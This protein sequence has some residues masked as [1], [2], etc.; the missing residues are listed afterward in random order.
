MDKT[1]RLWHISRSECLCCFKHSDFVTSIQFHPRD[2]RFFLAGSLDSKLRLWSIPDKSVAYWTHVA[3]MVTAVAFS[4]DGKTAI[5]GCLNGLCLFYDTEGLKIQSQLHV[6][7]SKG[8]KKGSKITGIK[9]MTNAPIDPNGEVKLLITSNDSRVRLYNLKDRNME[10]KFRGNENT[11]SQIH[12]TFSD[13]G[14][15]VICGSEDRKAYIWPTG[16]LENNQEKRPVEVFEAHSAIVT[17]AIFAPTRTRRLLAASG[18]PLYDLCNPPPVRLISRAESYASSKA[19]TENGLSANDADSS[20]HAE[21]NP[22]YQSRQGHPG[23]NI[24]ITADYTGKIKIFRQDCAFQK[25]RHDSWDNNSLFSKKMLGRSNSVA[26]RNSVSSGPRSDSLTKHPSNDR[27]LTWRNSIATSNHG[28]RDSLSK[29]AVAGPDERSVSP[30]KFLTKKSSGGSPRHN[31]TPLATST[32]PPSILTSSP[33]PSPHKASGD[34]P[35][36]SQNTRQTPENDATTYRALPIRKDD[37]LALA[38]DQSFMYWNHNAYSQQASTPARTP[39]LLNPE[40]LNPMS[41]KN[42]VVSQLSSE[43]SSAT[44]GGEEEDLR[45]QKCGDANFRATKGRDGKQRLIC[46]N[47]GTPQ[48]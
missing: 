11:C 12:A 5:A 3:D 32:D 34:G 25:R 8:K 1:V 35:D 36:A 42:S 9:T 7:S 16:A 13:D 22:G 31:S 41:R 24:I 21:V 47:C 28:S 48:P 15:Y 33:P 23:G 45:C 2:D 10:I 26:T 30:R 40:D 18:D 14:K 39:G 29:N 44:D 19:A 20:K 27:I 38:G 4:P 43:A 6:R 17:T 37:P 46:K